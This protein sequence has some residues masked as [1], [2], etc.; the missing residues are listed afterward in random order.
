MN[1]QMYR[2]N[3][4]LL[5]TGEYAVL[6]GALALAIPTKL[7]Q[8]LRV[9]EFE[10][11][12]KIAWES[13]NAAGEKWLDTRFTQEDLENAT[14]IA[15]PVRQALANVL[16]QAIKRKTTAPLFG[17]KFSTQLEFP[18]NW[19]LGS[20]ST[21]ISL[22][23]QYVGV[24]VFELSDATFGGSGYDVACAT[25]NGPIFY[26]KIPKGREI[27]SANFPTELKN[28]M[29]FVH[30]NQKQNSRSAIAQYKQLPKSTVFLEA[31]SAI[32]SAVAQTTQ[33][34]D[35]ADLLQRHEDLLSAQLQIPTIK[36]QLFSDYPSVIKSLGAWGGDFVLALSEAP[37]QQYFTAK[38]FATCL[39][40]DELFDV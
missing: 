4:K 6:D 7:G 34:A 23:A 39:A 26:R 24:D 22:V 30:L 28:H 14:Q 36:A 37:P 38:G 29:Y 40:F 2:A 27:R 35:L 9:S 15:D 17:K 8:R 3:G 32:T 33:F 19:G 21:L 13:Y 10:D 5:I 16:N 25:A 18:N 31:V 1:E 11:T 20:S 12:Q